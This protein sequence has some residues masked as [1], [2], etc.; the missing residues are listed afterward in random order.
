[1]RNPAGSKFSILSTWTRIPGPGKIPDDLTQVSLLPD[2]DTHLWSVSVT[3]GT[4]NFTEDEGPSKG[5]FQLTNAGAKNPSAKLLPASCGNAGVFLRVFNTR[6]IFSG[7]S[8][9]EFAS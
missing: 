3:G 8:A 2:F 5:P 6:V 9:N 1:V 4:L 7:F